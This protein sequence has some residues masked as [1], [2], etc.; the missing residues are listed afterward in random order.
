M[1]AK[2]VRVGNSQALMIPAS[3]MREHGWRAGDT[4]ELQPIASG[5]AVIEKSKRKPI[6]AMARR[7]VRDNE[8]M[9]RRLA[10]L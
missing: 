2:F 8:D 3:V 1:E 6:A 7:F 9:I 5:L 10:A 4:V